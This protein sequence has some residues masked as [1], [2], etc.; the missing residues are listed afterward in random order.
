MTGAALEAAWP[1]T[2]VQAGMLF[3]SA[4]APRSGI[5]C[6]DV[7][8]AVCGDLDVTCFERAWQHA[9]DRHP[10][11]R[12][13]FD[14]RDQGLFQVVHRRIGVP[15]RY[16]DWHR[17]PPEQARRMV[18]RCAEGDRRRGFDPSSAPL[19]RVSVFRT[20]ERRYQVRW[21]FHHAV[22]DGWSLPLVLGDVLTLYRSGVEGSAPPPSPRADFD[23]YLNWLASRDLAEAEA[24]W[25]T[26]LK[27]FRSPTPLPVSRAAGTLAKETAFARVRRQLPGTVTASLY[28][29][30]R[31]GGITLGTIVH[32]AWAVLLSRY[33]GEDDV[34]FGQC[35][36]GRSPD[37]PH[38]ESITGML[39]NTLP[40]RVT[41]PRDQTVLDWLRESQQQNSRLRRYEWTPLPHIQTISDVPRPSP[42]F[43]S[44][45]VLENYPVRERFSHLID[46]T[47]SGLAV[48]G[49]TNYPLTVTVLPERQRLSVQL[50]YSRTRFERGAMGR[51]SAQFLD[52]IRQIADA[53]GRSVRD[54]QLTHAGD[55]RVAPARDVHCAPQSVV[56]PLRRQARQTPDATAVV[57]GRDRCSYAE[58][59]RRST[60]AMRAVR[61][62]GADVDRRVGVCLDRSGE[63]PIWLIG[64]L[65]ARAPFVPLPAAWPALRMRLVLEDARPAFVLTNDRHAARFAQ[66]GVP[67]LTSESLVSDDH[68][69]STVEHV[70]AEAPAYVMYTSG[71]TGV[72]KG[73]Q[74]SH[75]ALAQVLDSLQSLVKLDA[76][77]EIL[78]LTDLSFDIS[79]VELLL[80]LLA[81]ARLRLTAF[82]PAVATAQLVRDAEGVTC[83]QATPAVWSLL[84]EAGWR[85]GGRMKLLCGGDVLPGDLAD[86]LRT[87]GRVWNV[88]GP[89]EAVIWSTAHELTRTKEHRPLPIGA[90]LP[91]ARVYILDPSGRPVPAGVNGELHIGGTALAQ[92]YLN[93]PA[94]TAQQFRPDPYG[95]LPGGRLYATGDI[96]RRMPGGELEFI[97]RTDT[98]VKLRGVRVDVTEIEAVLRQHRSIRDAAVT[99][100]DGALVAAYTLAADH[101][102][103]DAQRLRDFVAE[104]LPGHFV[105]V[106]FTRVDALPLTTG[107]KVDR[108]AIAAL[109]VATA[110]PVVNRAASESERVV[111]DACR[112]V[113]GLP[114]GPADDFFAMGGDSIKCLR[115]VARL[116]EVGFHLTA[117]E[118]FEHPRLSDLARI[119]RQVVMAPGSNTSARHGA[120]RWE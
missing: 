43:E 24:F 21:S 71:S 54:L 23:A 42:L 49:W 13:S 83:I 15:F 76:T 52:L 3:H 88:Y 65:K 66:L 104:R 40:T 41:V 79:L 1:A 93:R 118:V 74:V 38:V 7:T 32:A 91:H 72:P 101:T 48:R 8:F 10:T 58:L 35:V 30:A 99:T 80:P 119:A 33:S 112:E 102:T 82:D 117:R 81:G 113:L 68:V 67:V 111:A 77:D 87:A 89:T 17:L 9:A 63:L 12:I 4:L 114:V 28:E 95:D 39:M 60:V 85:G 94:I 25:R 31:R 18:R 120:E 78:A 55:L 105:P 2:A 75:Q 6:Q 34:V 62:A 27:G 44:I 22:L 64:L 92:G 109:P 61:R 50:D 98:Q 108:G 5:Y 16:V 29:Q 19:M 97:G 56:E 46:F 47:I 86:R 106:R 90:P 69:D 59:D 107:G 110:S 36:S 73:V 57:F 115:L 96:V 100:A 45:V 84:F 103:L 11:L 37:V 116:R 14:H 51:L 26:R 53:G 20:S 70:P